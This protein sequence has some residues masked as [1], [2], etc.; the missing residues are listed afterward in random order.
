ML[1]PHNPNAFTRSPL[2]RAGHRRNDADW[3][4]RALEAS[5]TRLI[6]FHKNRPFVI[7]EGGT[8][9]LGWLGAHARAGIAPA[10]ATLL[11]LGLDASGV[12]H[13][14]IDIP[15]AAPLES[16]GRFDDLRSFGAILPREDPRDAFISLRYGALGELPQGAKVGTSSLR[17]HAQVKLMRPDLEIVAFRGNVETRLRKLEQGIA[18]ATF[19]AVAGLNRLGQAARITRR[20]EIAEMLPAVAQGAVGLQVRETDG[21]TIGLIA[22]LDHPPTATCIAA[23]RSFLARLDGSCRTPIAGHAILDQHGGIT[24]SGELLAPDGSRSC[25]ATSTRPITQ[26]VELGVGVA[27]TVLEMASREPFGGTWDPEH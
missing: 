19:L 6:P 22:P 14:A 26:P 25:A 11:F 1:L 18:D 10:D 27:E 8:V 16:I 20:M 12:A 2:D 17:R 9:A 23:E 15:D 5:D 13:F 24:L 7:E 21:E 4:A 3:L